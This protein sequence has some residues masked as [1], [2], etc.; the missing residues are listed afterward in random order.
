M[1]SVGVMSGVFRGL[2]AGAG[3][4]QTSASKMV[5]AFGAIERTALGKRAS[6]EE[7]RTEKATE[8]APYLVL[9]CLRI[10]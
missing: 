4:I 10:T 7:T 6:V 8:F 1:G 2:G 3:L 9:L 5:F